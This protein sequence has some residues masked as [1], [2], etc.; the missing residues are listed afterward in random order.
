[1]PTAARRPPGEGPGL[2]FPAP[3]D[4]GLRQIV[5]QYNATFPTP[6]NP[7]GTFPTFRKRTPENQIIPYIKLPDKIASGDTFKSM[8]MRL[9]KA[10]KV[11]EGMNINLA[12]EGFNMFNFSNLLGYQNTLNFPAFGTPGDRSGQVFGTGG[13][14]AFQ[15]AARLRF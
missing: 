11:R 9:T 8:D 6:P 2:V 10:I 5:A 3:G 12:V 1:M 13:P 4:D 7:D 15:I 14:R